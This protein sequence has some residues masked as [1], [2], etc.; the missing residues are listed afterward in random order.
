MT[1]GHARARDIRGGRYAPD[2]ARM[3]PGYPGFSQSD[4]TY[5]PEACPRLSSQQTY[6]THMAN[7]S[8][9]KVFLRVPQITVFTHVPLFSQSGEVLSALS[10][11]AHLLV[12]SSGWIADGQETVS[13]NVSVLCPGIC[14]IP[15]P[16]T[17]SRSLLGPVS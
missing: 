17:D 7:S 3:E 13:L 12:V 15:I 11:P 10:G 2:I 4:S 5:R 6:E 14:V 1:S 16:K 9:K 8:M